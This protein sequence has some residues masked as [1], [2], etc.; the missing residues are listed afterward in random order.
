MKK[1]PGLLP[2]HLLA[3]ARKDL[4]DWLA[5]DSKQML[6]LPCTNGWTQARKLLDAIRPFVPEGVVARHWKRAKLRGIAFTRD[7]GA[8]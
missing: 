6:V 8:N 2:P 7:N 3:A 1:S 4:R 5:S